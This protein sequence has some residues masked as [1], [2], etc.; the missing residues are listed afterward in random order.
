MGATPSDRRWWGRVG[1]LLHV[2]HEVVGDALGVLADPAALVR[3][4]GVEVAQQADVPRVVRLKTRMRTLGTR[5]RT[6]GTR[7]R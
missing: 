2:R 5:M 3:A 4:H 7:M 1:C 6:L